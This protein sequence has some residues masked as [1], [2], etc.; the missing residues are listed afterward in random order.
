M[1]KKKS[2]LQDYQ[3]L[4]ESKPRNLGIYK[5]LV[6][7]LAWYD[8]KANSQAL[9]IQF[10]AKSN[11]DD[12]FVFFYRAELEKIS[13]NPKTYLKAV[14][15]L[16]NHGFIRVVGYMYMSKFKPTLCVTI[17]CTVWRKWTSN[18]TIEEFTE[19]YI[20]TEHTRT[21]N[22]NYSIKPCTKNI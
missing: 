3:Y 20:P 13:I 7:S 19:K 8:L 5:S 6:T 10:V 14:D 21:G 11:F 1:G 17:K 12:N 2:Y 22:Q 15:D 9:Y 16:V 4:G 18:T